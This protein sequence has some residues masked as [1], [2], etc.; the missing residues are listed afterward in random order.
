[1][2]RNVYRNMYGVRVVNTLNPNVHDRVVFDR[3]RAAALM[4]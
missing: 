1:V 2:H 3:E 4:R